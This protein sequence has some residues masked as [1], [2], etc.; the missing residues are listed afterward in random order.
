[1]NFYS[2]LTSIGASLLLAGAVNAQESWPDL[3]TGFKSGVFAQS[4]DTAYIGLGS[5]GSSL[6]SLDM[7][8]AEKI[9]KEMASFPGPDTSGAAFT[10]AGGNLYVFS[11]SGKEN[12]EDASPI[13]FT[14]GY[15]YDTASN[16]WSKLDTTVPV[17]L[18]GATAH[19]INDDQIAFFGGYNKELFDKY[20]Y[21]VIT[22]DKA[23]EPDAWQKIVDDYMGM[24]PADYRWNTKVLVYTISTNSWS[25]LGENPYQPNTGSALVSVDDGI[26]LVNGEVKPGLRTPRIK[27]VAISGDKLE[28]NEAQQLPALAGAELQE[29]LASP[30][31]G[32]SNGAVIVAGGANFHGAR[33]RSFAEDW[34]TH[35]GYPKAFNSE[36]YVMIDDAWKVVNSLPEGLAYGASF[37]TS[38]GIL[39]VGGEDSERAGRT[40]AFLMTWDGSKIQIED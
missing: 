22:T 26:L 20:L 9:W 16:I 8:A 40:E 14:T 4:G 28:W 1:M 15:V 31:A 12:A 37:Q 29:G 39:A 13:I 11:G 25:D 21:G 36:A 27:H 32:T 7:G 38:D 5:T 33:A 35:R 3:P 24:A 30:F 19:A 6:F 18:L 17:G 23:A 10:M 34:F 2:T